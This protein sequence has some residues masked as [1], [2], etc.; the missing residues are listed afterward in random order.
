MDIREMRAALGDKQSDFAE[1]YQI[2]LRTIQ[3]W[4][5]KERTPAPYV[6]DLLQ[7]RV[8]R[9]LINRK[10][11]R[12]P[13]SDPGKIKLPSRDEFV[14]SIDWF[15]AIR[16][17]IGE[18]VV[19]ALD[20]ALE[21]Q[22][23]FNGY[24]NERLIWVYGSDDL[25]KYDMLYVL[26]NKIDESDVIEECGLKFTSFERTIYDALSNEDVLFMQGT[27]EALSYYYYK[28]GESFERLFISPEYE[29]RFLELS[30]DAVDYYLE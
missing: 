25:L 10:T 21:I 16:N 3:K 14:S 12:I 9:D 19:F 17:I 29:D 2:P 27:I 4:E 6:I 23:T 26:G 13:K 7:R 8:E 1:R 22:G 20:S 15:L 5:T 24:S 18:D 11:F 30:R 28:N